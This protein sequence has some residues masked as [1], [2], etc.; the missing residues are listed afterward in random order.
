MKNQAKI[1]R[2]N[3]F[4]DAHPSKSHGSGWDSSALASFFFMC[5][6]TCPA[7]SAGQISVTARQN[8]PPHP[9]RL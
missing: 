9:H 8:S 5:G 6:R 3:S 2:F 4:S 1:E 7:L